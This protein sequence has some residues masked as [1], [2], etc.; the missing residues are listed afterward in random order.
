MSCL[1]TCIWSNASTPFMVFLR[2][3]SLTLGLSSWISLSFGAYESQYGHWLSKTTSCYCFLCF[4]V[5]LAVDLSSFL[6]YS[7]TTSS[8]ESSLSDA[9]AFGT[10]SLSNGDLSMSFYMN[11]YVSSSGYGVLAFSSSSRSILI[12]IGLLFGSLISTGLTS[13]GFWNLSPSMKSVAT[14]SS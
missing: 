14:S 7:I 2:S 8:V 12:S 6:S 11:F 3:L 1:R 4:F 10:T 9:S 5:F 13:T